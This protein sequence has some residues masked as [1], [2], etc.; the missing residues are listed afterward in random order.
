MKKTSSIAFRVLNIKQ[1]ADVSLNIQAVNPL[2][3]AG[4]GALM[5]GGAGGL[6]HLLK[7]PNKNEEEQVKALKRR[8]ILPSLLGA[9]GGGAVGVADNIL[10]G[11]LA[12][13]TMNNLTSKSLGPDPEI[14]LPAFGINADK[15]H[16]DVGW[17]VRTMG[18]LKGKGD[19]SVQ[20]NSQWK[21]LMD[22]NRSAQDLEKLKEHPIGTAERLR[23]WLSGR[24]KKQ[25]NTTADTSDAQFAKDLHHGALLGGGAGGLLGAGVGGLGGAGL[26]AAINALRSPAKTPE[27]DAER[28]AK[29]RKWLIGGGA[30]AGAGAGGYMGTGVGTLGALPA[31]LLG[32]TIRNT[33]RNLMDQGTTALDLQRQVANNTD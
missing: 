2:A 31:A 1:A 18:A 16:L 4:I 22:A 6:Y 14:N 11:K 19:P 25:S 20:V 21:E 8:L 29:L 30:L 26:A 27:Q 24:L 32:L 10:K 28:K 5:G 13:D 7:D 9:A 23:M 3:T 12:L 15:D 33:G 17:F